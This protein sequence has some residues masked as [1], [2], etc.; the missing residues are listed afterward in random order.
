VA[1]NAAIDIIAAT[2]LTKKARQNAPKEGRFPRRQR[3][4]DGD[5]IKYKV[6]IL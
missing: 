3:T 1:S 2:P 6:G 4:Q 5:L